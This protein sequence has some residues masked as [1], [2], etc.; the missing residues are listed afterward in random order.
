LRLSLPHAVLSSTSLF[1]YLHKRIKPIIF[2]TCI[3]SPK[4]QPLHGRNNCHVKWS[5]EHHCIPQ[6][7]KPK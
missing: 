6:L 3:T 1:L 7:T 5:P 4:G 2:I